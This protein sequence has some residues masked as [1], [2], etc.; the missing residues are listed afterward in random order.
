M[1]FLFFKKK[2]YIDIEAAFIQQR[3]QFFFE[4]KIEMLNLTYGGSYQPSP[5]ID[6]NH[7]IKISSV[8]LSF[9]VK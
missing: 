1:L 6:E 8:Y 9:F 5:N 2:I 7:F 3:H 4:K